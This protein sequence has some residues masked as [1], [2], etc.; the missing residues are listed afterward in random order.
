M[1]KIIAEA[2]LQFPVIMKT[3]INDTFF[4]W[5]PLG[6][7][8][9]NYVMNLSEN[10]EDF[11]ANLCK[12]AVIYPVIENYHL[13]PAGWINLAQL[14]IEESGFGG[15]EKNQIILNQ[16]REQMEDFVIQAETLIMLAFPHL[17]LNKIKSFTADELWEYLARAEWILKKQGINLEM[18]FETPAEKRPNEIAQELYPQGIDPMTT[19]D[20]AKLRFDWNYIEYPF[21]IGKNWNNEENWYDRTGFLST[22][23][24]PTVQSSEIPTESW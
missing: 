15:Q 5:R 8:E 19:L 18:N 24:E 9:Y 2:K 7:D 10:Q 23:H 13:A 1:R 11:H 16:Y 14:I 12:A 3:T 22:T 6:R 21:I 20:P 4:I 17:E